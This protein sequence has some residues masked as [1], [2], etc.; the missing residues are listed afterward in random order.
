MEKEND[1]PEEGPKE[2]DKNKEDPRERFRRLT[3]Q[4]SS[5]KAEPPPPEESDLHSMGDT[6][7]SPFG[8]SHDATSAMA[9]DTPEEES[10]PIPP[11]EIE[12]ELQ[13][14]SPRP[15]FDTEAMAGEQI[16]SETE[17][18]GTGSEGEIYQ[19]SDTLS[20]QDFIKKEHT[21]PPLLGDTPRSSAPEVDSEGM[22]LPRRVTETDLGATQV[23]PTAL[24]SSQD[25]SDYY[26]LAPRPSKRGGRWEG[27]GC[28]IRMFIRVMFIFIAIGLAGLTY[29]M[30]QYYAIASTLP[31]VEDLLGRA[32]TF[33][34]TR[35]LDRND[36]LL[37]EILDP[38]AGRRT[39]VKL[40]EISPFMV[41][42]TIATEDEGFYS[43]PGFSVSA[44]IR[45]YFQNVSSGEVVSGASTITQQVVRMLVLD[46]EE[47]YQR[48]YMRKVK[49]AILATEVTR[50]FSKDD[51]LEL[52]LNESY[53]GNLAYGVEAAAQT[54]FG[55]SAD[56]LTLAQASFLAGLP[57]APSVYDVHTNTDATFTRQQDVLR[58]MIEASQEQDCIYVSNSPQS[59]CVD[60]ANASAAWYAIQDYE[61]PDPGVEMRFPHWVNYIHSLLEEQYDSQTIYRS[62]FTVETTLDPGLQEAALASIQEQIAKLEENKVQSGALVAIYPPTGEILVMVGSAD[63]YNEEIDG[64][65][66]MAV[67]P[68]QPGSSIKPFT[69]VAAF[70]KGWT[71]A[72]LIWDVE[73]EFPQSEDPYEN[74][75]PYVPV[76]YDEKFH[77]PV[78]VRSAL[79]NSYNIPAVKT[80]Q[81]VGIYDNPDTP[82]KDGLVEMAHRLG[83]TDLNEDIYGFALTLGG[84][85]VKLLDMTAA[86]A[87]FANGGLKVPPVA[88]TRI[89]DHEGNV[90]YEY[91]PPAPEQVIRAEHAY[92]ISSIISDNP[93]RTPA[94]GPNSSLKL[95]FQAAA[96]T[97]TTDDF[98]DNWTLGYTPDSAVGVWVGNPDYTPMQNTSGLT[99]AA[100]IWNEFMQIAIQDLTGN[101]PRF[102]VKPAGVIDKVICAIS[103]TEPT[104]W[105][106]S[107]RSEYFA[108]D[109]PPLP[110][111]EDLWQE[112]AIDTWTLLRTSSECNKFKDARLA[113]NVTES[114]AQ[115]W[116]TETQKGKDWAEEMGFS[117]NV[118]FVPERQCTAEDD[119]AILEFVN[120]IDGQTI[121]ESPLPIV[122][123]AWGGNRFK[124]FR[125][126]YRIEGSGSW[127]EL[128]RFTEQ[129]KDSHEIVVWDLT[130]IPSGTVSLRLFMEGKR[131]S[132]AEVTIKLNIQVPTPT[133]TQTP[134]PTP[135]DTPAPTPTETG[136]S[137]PQPT[138]TP[139]E[140]LPPTNTP[141]PTPT[142]TQTQTPTQTPT[143][144]PP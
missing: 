53:Y 103:G 81:F 3:S 102:F 119:P 57:Q 4:S 123:R 2:Q 13:Q 84:G 68:R 1:L 42:A 113:L 6:E 85:E 94:F 15:Q 24:T 10:P 28:F 101:N 120:F 61:F 67:S 124:N 58:L 130:E 95:P 92:L 118:L 59:V 45:A 54:Y 14:K 89:T 26:S 47:A 41:A 23:A 51:I 75:E 17:K 19:D 62:G 128:G 87:V 138:N 90:V 114:W 73:T 9:S 32:S 63:F 109:Q 46:P 112:V 31:D 122:I 29:M 104:K 49:E 71:P 77:G 136:T 137:T 144:T 117:K 108:S 66:N 139:T 43:H 30:V 44:I 18:T 97:G 127:V 78:T 93:A 100:P 80:L 83:I 125:L 135:T 116:I 5:S 40:E 55:T 64:Q 48:S 21:P 82:E 111:S 50:Q 131:I 38:N 132:S 99:G 52:Y 86:F 33:E 91:E 121:N 88:I 39:Y 35:I 72:T 110:A 142:S 69:Y 70:E 37:Y 34:T 8:S 36:N 20:P 16:P 134:T 11:F 140:T 22:P 27:A 74:R 56:K 76:N 65:I 105:C 25:S 143:P 7:G 126:H 141:T 12:P 107:Q 79:A 60:D 96:K 98:R 115:K 129:Y 133:P 106:P